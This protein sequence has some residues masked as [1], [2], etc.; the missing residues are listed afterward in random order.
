MHLRWH[1][2]TELPKYIA[3]LQGLRERVAA[4]LKKADVNWMQGRFE[5]HE[6]D[7]YNEISN[8][9]VSFLV[10]LEQKQVDQL[11]KSMGER[12]SEFEKESRMSSED[13]INETARSFTRLAEFIYGDLSDVQKKDIVQMVL[14]KEDLEPLRIRLYR[15]RQAEFIALL[16]NKP[17][18]NRVRAYIARLFINPEKSYPDY[19]RIP[20]DRH[21]RYIVESFLRFDRELVTPAQRT[22][23]CKKIDNLIQAF[24]ELNTESTAADV[25]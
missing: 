14:H 16:R 21:D 11:E 24:R 22:Y 18:K 19:F 23:A 5:L 3:T 25:R 17:D 15:E 7:L 6:A 8:D 10:S 20:A 2:K 12:I 9:V 13:R 4:G 1:R